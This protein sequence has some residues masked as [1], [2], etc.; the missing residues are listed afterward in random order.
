MKEVSSSN[1]L[2]SA[3]PSKTLDQRG[4]ARSVQSPVKRGSQR[5]RVTA[6]SK[7]SESNAKTCLYCHEDKVGPTGKPMKIYLCKCGEAFHHMCA[8]QAGCDDMTRCH[9]CCKNDDE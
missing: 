6:P 3:T 7:Q 4:D 2:K 8:G 9:E 5:A 1:T